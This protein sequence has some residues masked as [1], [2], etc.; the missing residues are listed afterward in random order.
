MLCFFAGSDNRT[1]GLKK[2]APD[3][4]QR[5][6]GERRSGK[7]DEY[8][9]RKSLQGAET[10]ERSPRRRGSNPFRSTRIRSV[11]LGFI[12]NMFALAIEFEVS[13]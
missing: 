4:L 10:I 1:H 3:K 11:E 6:V 9:R 5:L 8:S 2:G 7:A 13:H 12:R